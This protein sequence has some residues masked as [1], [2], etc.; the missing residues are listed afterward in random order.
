MDQALA[1]IAHLQRGID[2]ADELH[3]WVLGLACFGKPTAVHAA[4]AAAR[5][6]L[7]VWERAEPRSRAPHERI[8]AAEAWLA[9]PC[10]DHAEAAGRLAFANGDDSPLKFTCLVVDGHEVEAMPT[11]FAH[12][13]ADNAVSAS[14]NTDPGL[15]AQCAATGM[16]AAMAALDATS[17]D[18]ETRLREMH[19]SLVDELARFAELDATERALLRQLARSPADVAC[20]QVYADWLQEHRPST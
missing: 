14:W 9:C 18:G 5:N 6:A 13:S 10:T 17:A 20:R 19:A 2:S 1:F 16:A 8:A 7:V 12:W 4:V 15:V 3:A 11:I